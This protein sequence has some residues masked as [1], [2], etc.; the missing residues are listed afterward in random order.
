MSNGPSTK[1]GGIPVIYWMALAALIIGAYYNAREAHR[2]THELACHVDHPTLC[3]Y[4]K[5]E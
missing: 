5:P 3:K 1:P 4:W 2:H